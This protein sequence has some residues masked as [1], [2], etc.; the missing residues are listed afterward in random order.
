M[1]DAVPPV[2]FSSLMAMPEFLQTEKFRAFMRAYRQAIR[3]VVESPA[4]EIAAAE[5][6]FFPAISIEAITAAIARY[7]QLGTWNRDTAITR[8]QY[9]TAMDVFIFAGVFKERYPYE[10]VVVSNV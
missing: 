5:A 1:G 9:E 3:F 7:Q 6:S 8:Q 10:D 4:Q 2:A